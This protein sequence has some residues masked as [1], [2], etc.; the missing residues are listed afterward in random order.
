MFLM[1]VNKDYKLTNKDILLHETEKNCFLHMWRY[2]RWVLVAIAIACANRSR[3]LKFST[4]NQNDKCT[5]E[6]LTITWSYSRIA[7]LITDILLTLYASL[8]WMVTCTDCMRSRLATS[9]AVVANNA[10]AHDNFV[11][12][13]HFQ[14]MHRRAFVLKFNNDI[15]C[16][17][18][19]V[20]HTYTSLLTRRSLFY[21]HLRFQSE[22]CI[23]IAKH[24][25]R[26]T[27]TCDA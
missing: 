12:R 24:T 22:L 14:E 20:H 23:W 9:Y 13:N 7:H 18:T 1:G 26:K 11:T 15:W 6:N 4:Q 25:L 21:C 17:T 8:R 16:P 27:R 10:H 5:T 19:C 2:N 3:D